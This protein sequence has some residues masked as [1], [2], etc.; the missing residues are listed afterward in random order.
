MSA[1][2]IHQQVVH[3]EVL[4]R[5]RP[6]IL[7]H[8]WVGSWR[9]WLVTMQA[10][11]SSYRCYALDLWGFGDTSHAPERYTLDEQT[12]LVLD[13]MDALGIS[14][15]ALFGHGLG[16]GVA[17]QFAAVHP[18]RVDRLLL[19]GYPHQSED[20]DTRLGTGS[21]EELYEWLHS[22]SPNTEA[23]KREALK[24]DPRA[25]Q[26]AI[27]EM[28]TSQLQEHLQHPALPRLFVYGEN[29]PAVSKPVSD[30]LAGTD[31]QTHY[32]L[33]DNGGHAPMVR[34][35]EKFCRLVNDFLALEPL[36]TPR[37]LQL[38]DEWKRRFR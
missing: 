29:D 21:P 28:S 20:L 11:S 3:Y 7:L 27:Q 30:A 36:E 13:F 4:G 23:L 18:D 34:I 17:A 38:K 10:L 24:M 31:Y 9:D 5:G 6:V 8:G 32:F 14:K 33:L 22:G 35:P 19:V 25:L 2:I 37:K 16:A 1:L 15:I 12:G 26:A